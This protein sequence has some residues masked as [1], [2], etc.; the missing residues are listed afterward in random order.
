M[1]ARG[2]ALVRLGAKWIIVVIELNTC[3]RRAVALIRN[4]DEH[5]ERVNVSGGHVFVT[6]VKND[7]N[8]L[9]GGS[10]RWR[11][12]DVHAQSSPW[13]SCALTFTI[14]RIQGW[15]QH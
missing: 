14:M 2:L 15:M 3:Y 8:P 4:L 11:R 13:S 10:I 9:I 5:H 12:T 1:A 7:G 6:A